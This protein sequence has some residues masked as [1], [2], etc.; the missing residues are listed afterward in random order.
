MTVASLGWASRPHEENHGGGSQ[1]SCSL[2]NY[3][4]TSF[5]HNAC[6][7]DWRDE[8]HW[9]AMN[10]VALREMKEAK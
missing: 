3:D 1:V 10:S 2:T 7:C 6:D 5:A 9:N 8:P 4:R